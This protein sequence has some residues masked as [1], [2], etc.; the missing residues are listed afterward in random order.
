M[1]FVPLEVV[2]THRHP[3]FIE[4][5]ELKK[6]DVTIIRLSGPSFCVWVSIGVF[7]I[8]CTNNTTLFLIVLP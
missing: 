5:K 1:I 4:L 2:D 6:Y 8:E 7:K 3:L